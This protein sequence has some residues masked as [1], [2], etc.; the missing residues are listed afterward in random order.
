[1]DARIPSATTPAE[2]PRLS[3]ARRLALAG[4]AVVTLAVAAF[5]VGRG[6]ASDSNSGGAATGAATTAA[7]S[8]VGTPATI[9]GFAFSPPTVTV[10]AGGAVTWTNKDGATHAIK[11]DD[12]SFVS[13]DLTEGQS[14]T[15][16]FK[17]AGTFPYICSIHTFMKGTVVVQP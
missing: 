11:S 4:A 9:S 2:S 14:F 17:T 15:A 5:A 8:G 16:T 1:M 10:K 12:G 7:A 13:S 3:P 6:V